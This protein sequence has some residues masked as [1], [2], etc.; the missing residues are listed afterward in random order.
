MRNSS[1]TNKSIEAEVRKD[2]GVDVFVENVLESK[3]ISED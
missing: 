3:I 1:K 2:L